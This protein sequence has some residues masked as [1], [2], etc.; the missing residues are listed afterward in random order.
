MPQCADRLCSA[1][2][3]HLLGTQ[4]TGTGGWQ[5]S[6]FSVEE[7]SQVCAGISADFTCGF[8]AVVQRRSGEEP[9]ESIAL[10]LSA[11][12]CRGWAAHEL[13]RTFKAG[14]AAVCSRCA[15]RGIDCGIDAW[16][17]GRSESH[18]VAVNRYGCI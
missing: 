17:G 11:D 6:G 8:A 3:R 18:L 12:L 5:Q 10:G 16:A 15:R 13:P 9:G 4:G 2:I 14:I 1:G 7:V